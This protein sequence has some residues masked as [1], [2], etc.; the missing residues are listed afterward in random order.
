MTGTLDRTGR[1]GIPLA[2]AR[3]AVR[4]QALCAAGLLLA[5]AGLVVIGTGLPARHLDMVGAPAGVNAGAGDRRDITAH[6][7]PSVAR[8]A[9]RPSDVVVAGR[10]DL[11]RFSC[12]LH[13]SHDA[14]ATWSDAD[15]PFPEGEEAPPRCYAPDAVFDAAGVLYASFTTLAGE[16]N[17]PHAV[18]LTSSADGGR[19]FTPPVRA[20]GPL[21]F[22][23]RLA[24][25][26]HRPGRL[27]LAWLQADATATL[28]FPTTGNPIEAA[29]SDDGGRTWSAPVRVS[30]VH[31]ARVV[32]PAMVVSGNR[33]LVGYLDLGDDRLDYAGAHGGRG[34]PP[35]PGPWSV[36]LAR[37]GDGGATWRETLVDG[38]VVPTER[39]VPFLAPPPALA[40]DPSG[41]RVYVGWADARR[42]DPDVWV[43]ASADGGATFGRA[44]RVN[45]PPA[46]DRTSQYRPALGVAP[47]GRV[48]A[49]YYDRR[50]DRADIRN[51]VSLQSSFDHG[52]HFG[53]ALTLS[54]RPFDSRVGFGAERSLADLGSRLAVVS[55]RGSALA[56]WTDTS[57]GTDVSGKQDLVRAVVRVSRGSRLRRVMT[58]G[59]ALVCAAAVLVFASTSRRDVPR[60][61][62]NGARNCRP[63]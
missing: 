21:A 44:V 38:G 52:R 29:G 3:R 12:S 31:R 7:S 57:A 62:P 58:T 59:G 30:P 63:W 20:L 53:R 55:A 13:V 33:L 8:S 16:G 32:A 15:L 5:G 1:R 36:V 47:G 50:G 45:D 28:G 49:V 37:S 54:A 11:P 61:P 35:F 22:G 43:R 26:A 24:A 34:G 41:H 18:W 17:R 42:G 2:V 40:A 46:R 56:V 25:D 6:N 23:P 51:Q 9:R 19:R 4:P 48:D 39:I 60:P 10:V 14:G 27:H